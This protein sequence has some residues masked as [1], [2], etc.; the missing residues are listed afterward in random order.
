MS[1]FKQLHPLSV[2]INLHPTG[3]REQTKQYTCVSILLSVPT[4]KA[5]LSQG[6]RHEQGSMCSISPLPGQRLF[7]TFQNYSLD[8]SRL[9]CPC[10]TVATGTC[11][12]A[13]TRETESQG[14]SGSCQDKTRKALLSARS[15]LFL[16]TQQHWDLHCPA[17]P[18][19]PPP[20]FACLTPSYQPQLPLVATR[21]SGA[22]Q[23]GHNSTPAPCAPHGC[24]AVPGLSQ[25]R[26]IT[27]CDKESNAGMK[28]KGRQ[29]GDNT[30]Q[31]QVGRT[32]VSDSLRY[33]PANH[34]VICPRE[35]FRKARK[36]SILHSLKAT[37]TP[38]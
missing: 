8:L 21:Q 36:I 32:S 18:A 4:T 27:V 5:S 28:K 35:D 3:M 2:L 29:R 17:Q 16:P 33:L 23:Q 20:A 15:S 22:P 19:P 37:S 11:M 24:V 26:D 25:L 1:F 10:S 7:L 14:H 9:V 12:S 6:H 30:K 13:A 34:C 31:F 38:L